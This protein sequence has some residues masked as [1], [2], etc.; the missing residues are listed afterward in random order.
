[1]SANVAS[2]DERGTGKPRKTDAGERRSLTEKTR[3][4]R[5]IRAR[6]TVLGTVPDLA[7]FRERLR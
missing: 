7:L 1:M 2:T 4:L 6:A 5:V 3:K